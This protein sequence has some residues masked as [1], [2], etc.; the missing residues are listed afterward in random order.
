MSELREECGV[1]GIYSQET[2]D[3]ASTTYYGL[4]ALQHRGQES[5]GIVVNDEGLFRYDKDGGLVNDVFT[6]PVLKKLGMGQM[7]IGHDRY[8]TTG[9]NDR[10]NAQPIVVKHH[11][12]KMA[13]AHN[14]NIVNS[15][16][17]RT[18]LE[19]EGCIFHTTSDTEVI[20]YMITKERIKTHSIEKALNNAMSKIEGAYSL[21]IMSPQ[22]ILA[23]R[24]PYGFRPLC[25]GQR[26]DGAYVVASETCALD[27]VGAEYIRDVEPGE[28]VVFS[29]NG[30]KSIKD[31]C[32]T[33][34]HKICIFEYLYFARP[35]SIIEGKSVH[36]AREIAGEL[37]AEQFPVD[38]DIVVGVPDSGIDAAIGYAHKSGIPYGM[39]FIKNKY[40]G[41]TFIAPGQ[42]N[43]EDKVRIKLNVIKGT[44]EGK[45]VVLVDDS[46]VR[47]T[48]ITRIIDLVRK[49][50]AKEVHVMSS[51]PAF[52]DACYYGVDVDTKEHLIACQCDYDMKKI[53]EKV[54]ADS[55]GYLDVNSLNEIIG[56]EP[57]EGF[58]SACF[59]TGY[60]TQ[61]PTGQKDRFEE[62]INGAETEDEEEDY[63]LY[64]RD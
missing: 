40:I 29:K 22:K 6:K 13:V 54:G 55:V 53:A 62:K 48:T 10:D 2:Q 11:K 12:G 32:G 61:V 36:R 43:R 25:Y 49:A 17:L 5:C 37:L 1:F 47:G 63:E 26:S 21:V 60:P 16:E 64:L 8:S 4:F 18:Q 44:V 41:R 14:G 20:A 23:C 39:G 51:A 52:T 38:A 28:I 9:N 7:A 58:C 56:N 42:K 50:G 33:K 57:G 15:F 35:D 27:A 3:V 34:P 30:V 31:H 24:D 59:G 19:L 45:R 46:I